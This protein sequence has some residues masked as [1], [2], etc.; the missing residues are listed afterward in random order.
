MRVLICACM[1]MFMYKCNCVDVNVTLIILQLYRQASEGRLFRL[2]FVNVCVRVRSHS[3]LQATVR[4][5][6][7]VRA[8]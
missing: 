5:C 1:N 6:A 7:L 3:S 8:G 4:P 2:S